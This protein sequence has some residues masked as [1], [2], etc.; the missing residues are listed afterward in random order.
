M[1]AK[2]LTAQLIPGLPKRFCLLILSSYILRDFGASW[3]VEE[4]PFWNLPARIYSGRVEFDDILSLY[5][6]KY[7]INYDKL[8]LIPKS[9]NKFFLILHKL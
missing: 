1:R 2:V 9:Y 5:F 6:R 7:Y 3:Q 8:F 4:T